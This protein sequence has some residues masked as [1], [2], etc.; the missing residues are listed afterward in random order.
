[1]GVIGRK[2]PSSKKML[3]ETF[4]CLS[5]HSV[6]PSKWAVNCRMKITKIDRFKDVRFHNSLIFLIF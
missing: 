3:L 4:Q 1:M 5:S 2:C 6:F